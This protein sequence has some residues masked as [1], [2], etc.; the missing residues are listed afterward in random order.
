[1]R[2][3]GLLSVIR[4]VLYAIDMDPVFHVLIAQQR[5][6]GELMIEPENTSPGQ[7][8]C[9][10]FASFCLRLDNDR[11][12]SSWFERIDA[13]I[14]KYA[15]NPEQGCNRLVELKERLSDLIEFLDPD[16]ARFPLGHE[17][18]SRYLSRAGGA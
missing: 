13:G 14:V 18:R 17:E 12:F 1:M 11:D 2:L 8:R 6:I 16:L 9:I 15:Y 3:V 7:G 10:G 4:Q 5:A